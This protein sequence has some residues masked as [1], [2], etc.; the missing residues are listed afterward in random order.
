METAREGKKKEGQ[1]DSGRQ[2]RQEV[3]KE[4]GGWRGDTAEQ[5]TNQRKKRRGMSQCF[6]DYCRRGLARAAA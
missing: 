4:L 5:Q 6:L 2:G 3:H 1:Q